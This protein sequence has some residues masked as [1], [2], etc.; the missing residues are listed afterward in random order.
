[1]AVCDI[2]RK[3]TYVE[4]GI[5]YKYNKIKEYK[6]YKR[7]KVQ[8]YG[9]YMCRHWTEVVEMVDYLINIY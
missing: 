8:K 4:K 6:K 9:L 2:K 7:Q 5:I 3:L 1:M